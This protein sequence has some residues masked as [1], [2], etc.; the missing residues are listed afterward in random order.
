LQ[1]GVDISAFTTAKAVVETRLAT[2]MEAWASLVVERAQAL[3]GSNTSGLERHILADN[4]GNVDALAHFIDVTA[5]NQPRH[6]TSL[7]SHHDQPHSSPNPVEK[8]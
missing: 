1:E 2:N 3:H 8:N 7:V 6:S 5:L 4:L